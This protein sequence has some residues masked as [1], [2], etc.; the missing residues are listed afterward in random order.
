ML[1]FGEEL[2][3]IRRSRK[4]RQIDIAEKH[5]M[6]GYSYSS[7]E[8]GRFLPDSPNVIKLL[9][10]NFYT[11]AEK[12]HLSVTHKQSTVD[13]ERKKNDEKYQKE[14][15]ELQEVR[16]YQSSKRKQ[17]RKKERLIKNIPGFYK[18]LNN[19]GNLSEVDINNP[20]LQDIR[21]AVSGTRYWKGE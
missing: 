16:D 21:E 17:A 5:D 9:N 13:H 10:S 19:L 14:L 18:K 11:A 20:K 3:K 12:E 2:R 7:I 6:S 4:L 8:R 1:Q 15:R